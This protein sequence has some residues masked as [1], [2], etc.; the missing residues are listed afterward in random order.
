MADLTD[1]LNLAAGVDKIVYMLNGQMVGDGLPSDPSEKQ[2]TIERYR[3]VLR[4]VLYMFPHAPEEV[5]A[6]Q[7]SQI[8]TSGLGCFGRM[9][10]GIGDSYT[11][12][13]ASVEI[14]EIKAYYGQNAYSHTLKD[15]SHIDRTL[16]ILIDIFL[17]N[18]RK[19]IFE[20]LIVQY[21][22]TYG[23]DAQH[24]RNKFLH[25]LGRT[26]AIPGAE[27]ADYSD[28][29]AAHGLTIP[30]E[31]LIRNFDQQYTPEK[32]VEFLKQSLAYGQKLDMAPILAFLEYHAPLSF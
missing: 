16:I 18:F 1:G 4:H 11:A 19:S 5:Q 21:K 32:I 30:H 3:I 28:P 13:T 15:I 8:A 29:Y 20:I 2:S 27:L 26:R 23:G 17:R 7:M 25:I 9:M 31:E 6:I 12:L 14:P 10:G 24:T 22:A